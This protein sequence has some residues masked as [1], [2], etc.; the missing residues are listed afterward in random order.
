MTFAYEIID[1]AV[2]IDSGVLEARD[3]LAALQAAYD[4]MHELSRRLSRDCYAPGEV[5]RCELTARDGSFR[6]I[7]REIQ[8]EDLS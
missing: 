1:G 3:G 4:T 8:K 5:L 2:I 7:S 6:A